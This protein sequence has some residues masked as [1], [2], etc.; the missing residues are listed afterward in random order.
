MRTFPA[1]ETTASGTF[2]SH[3]DVHI[4]C[5][6]EDRVRSLLEPSGRAPGGLHQEASSEGATDSWRD[7]APC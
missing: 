2:W 6:G 7:R 3:G 5:T 1:Q 4:P